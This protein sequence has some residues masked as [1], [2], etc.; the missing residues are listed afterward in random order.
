MKVSDDLEVLV[1]KDWEKELELWFGDW[2]SLPPVEKQVPHHLLL[3]K[4]N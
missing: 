4:I 1:A 2:K 3:Y